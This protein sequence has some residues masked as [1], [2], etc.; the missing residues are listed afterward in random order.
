MKVTGA[1]VKEKKWVYP[2]IRKKLCDLKANHSA[3]SIV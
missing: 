3:H 2:L 1:L